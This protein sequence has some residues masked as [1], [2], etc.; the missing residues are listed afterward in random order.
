VS[1]ADQLRATGLEVDVTPGEKSQ[2]DVFA[3]GELVYSKQQLGRFPED[4]EV[5]DLLAAR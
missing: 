3:D 4:G 5:A 2:F 1:L